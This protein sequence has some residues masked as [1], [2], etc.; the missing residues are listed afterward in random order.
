MIMSWY[1]QYKDLNLEGGIIQFYKILGG[2]DMRGMDTTGYFHICTDG[3][4]LP[5]MFQDDDDFIAGINRIGLCYLKTGVII[6]AYVL[7]DNHVH[8]VLYGTML[9]CKSFINTYKRLTGIWILNKQGIGDYLRLLPTEIIRIENEESLLNNRTILDALANL[10][11]FKNII[12]IIPTND[13]LVIFVDTTKRISLLKS[14]MYILRYNEKDDKCVVVKDN[15]TY[16]SGQI[17]GDFTY[18]VDNALIISYCEYDGIEQSP[19][20]TINLGQW[21]DI[22]NRTDFSQCQI[23]N[24]LLLPESV[25]SIIPEVKI[26]SFQKVE[27]IGGQSY[28]GWYQFY[29][30]YKINNNNYN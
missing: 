27:F 3:R 6:I 10:N 5:W 19:M 15:L 21:D 12:H 30:R 14:T 2:K 25:L 11:V 18:N 9:Q 22:K 16:T 17:T 29:I 8:F 28:K 26:P 13:E 4:K 1:S 24:D 23:P 7:M 20:R